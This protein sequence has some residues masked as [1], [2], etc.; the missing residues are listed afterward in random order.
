[1][2]RS[3][4]SSC[5]HDDIVV[6]VVGM[7][8]EVMERQQAQVVGKNQQQ[9]QQAQ[10]NDLCVPPISCR[11]AYTDQKEKWKRLIRFICST[12]VLVTTCVYDFVQVVLSFGESY[13]VAD[14]TEVNIT[15]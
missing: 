14:L 6:E 2:H 3:S 5:D 15:F 1:M 10:N 8:A 4:D 11:V 12:V 9:S 7:Q 13:M